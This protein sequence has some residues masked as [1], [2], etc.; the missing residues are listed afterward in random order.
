MFI[1]TANTLN[2]PRPLLDRME[3][4]RSRGKL[5]REGQ[6]AMRYLLPK[7]IKANGLEPK[8]IWDP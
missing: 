4:I 5:R 6:I 7:Q 1:T 3:M 8:E 2:I